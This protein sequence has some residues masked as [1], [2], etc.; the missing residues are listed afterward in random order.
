MVEKKGLGRAVSHAV[1]LFGAAIV[2]FPLY[3]ALVATSHTYDVL[4]G[5]T[6]LWFGEE[7]T[8]TSRRC[9]RRASRPRAA[10]PSGS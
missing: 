10:S 1:L 2:L 4:I 9:S 6:P 8:G 7:F 5:T 3:I